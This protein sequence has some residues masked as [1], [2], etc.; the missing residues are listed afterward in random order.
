MGTTYVLM[1]AGNISGSFAGFETNMPNLDGSFSYT[2]TTVTFTVNASDVLFQNSF[3]Q[4]VNDSPC[5]AA[6]TN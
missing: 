4:P 3:E 5:I 1:N 6:F 2:L